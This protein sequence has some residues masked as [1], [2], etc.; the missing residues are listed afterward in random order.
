MLLLNLFAI[1]QESL[2][3]LTQPV[4]VYYV[5]LRSY[6]LCAVCQ[7]LTVVLLIYLCIMQ[8]NEIIKHAY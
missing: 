2:M 3:E 4:E 6:P 8:V 7:C 1:K 5:Q